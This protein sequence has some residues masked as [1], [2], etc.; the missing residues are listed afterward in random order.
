MI[1]QRRRRRRLAPLVVAG[2]LA[3]GLAAAEGGATT[4][5]L[6]AVLEDKGILSPEEAQRLRDR[7]A[8]R[9][10][11]PPA[12]RSPVNLHPDVAEQYEPLIPVGDDHPSVRVNKFRVA[13]R[14]G[15]HRF[16]VRGR[17]MADYAYTDFDARDTIDDHRVDRGVIGRQGSF[18]RRAR[19]GALGVMWDRWEWQSEIDFRD[20]EVRFANAY[21]AYLFDHGRLAV[22]HFKKP[23]SMESST[24]SRRLTFIERATP[25]DAYRPDR[26]LGI[27][28]ETLQP[29][30]YAAAGAFTTNGVAR[31]RDVTEGYALAARAS[32]SPIETSSMWT[33]LGASALYHSNTYEGFGDDRSYQ[34]VRMRSRLGT[35]AVDGRFIGRRDLDDVKDFYTLVGE[36][37]VGYGP[38]SLQGEYLYQD[39]NRVGDGPDVKHRGW[40]TQ[41]S[42]FLTG[43][44]RNYRS[45]S[46]DFGIMPVN[47]PLSAGGIGAWE[48]AARF[49]RADSFNEGV[50]SDGGQKMD[51]Y[52]L[53][54]N[55]YPED[56]IIFKFNVIWLDGETQI[57]GLDGFGK[58]TKGWV[59]AFRA[60]YEF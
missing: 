57:G 9:E 32:I 20:N 14:D 23:F 44:Q 40:Y 8:P 46:G 45:F 50:T 51:H 36:W 38:W 4:E 1:N 17:L 13:T 43:D 54:L 15:R 21:I 16:G 26:Q 27:M 39:F 2:L 42:W 28:Y 6:I 55:W 25:V 7:D 52:T 33:H 18:I 53:A 60:Q 35:R 56:D 30:W 47:R 59:Y 10:A 41:A 37:G 48:L 3:P 29:G 22:G 19:L 31:N 34:D 49:A 12:P 5:E 24:S 58:Q 11:P